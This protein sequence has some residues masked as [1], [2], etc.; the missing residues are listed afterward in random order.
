MA[1]DVSGTVAT[2]KATMKTAMKNEW[3]NTEADYDK[4][5][6]FITDAIGT[7]M[8]HIKDNADVTG[9]TSGVDTV[10]GGVD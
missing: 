7:A 10:A 3:G 1:I 2:M 8:Q 9:V 6:Q 4:L 5:A